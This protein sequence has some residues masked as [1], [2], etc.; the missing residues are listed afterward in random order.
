[1]GVRPASSGQGQPTESLLSH[2]PTVATL[3]VAQEEEDSGKGEAR[4]ESPRIPPAPYILI[5]SA[6]SPLPH[7]GSA[8]RKNVWCSMQTFHSLLADRWFGSL[9]PMVLSNCSYW[10]PRKGLVAGPE[11][12]SPAAHPFRTSSQPC[13]TLAYS[14]M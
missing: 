9:K 6:S 3:K 2:C 14:F 13:A 4:L 11:P 12:L 5:A 1:M 10:R 7:P 8:H